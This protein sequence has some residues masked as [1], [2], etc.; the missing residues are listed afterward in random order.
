MYK[1]TEKDL[2]PEGLTNLLKNYHVM[3]TFLGG[4]VPCKR[5]DGSMIAY[6]VENFFVEGINTVDDLQNALRS[7]VFGFPHGIYLEARNIKRAPAV[8]YNIFNEDEQRQLKEANLPEEAIIL[9]KNACFEIADQYK[10]LGDSK[11]KK[12][13]DD[14][15]GVAD[16]AEYDKYY[17]EYDSMQRNEI[18]DLIV[19]QGWDVEF[20]FKPHF[21]SKAECIRFYIL[22][23]HN[24]KPALTS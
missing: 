15:D 12:P 11:E 24:I 3:A 17:K 2:T 10:D 6:K 19:E 13:A 9:M 5:A 7:E 16:Q 1:P 21:T 22:H 20:K 8:I 23:K 18:A 4:L 14:T